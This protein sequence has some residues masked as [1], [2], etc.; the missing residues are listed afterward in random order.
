MRG[1]TSPRGAGTQGCR[2]S[3]WGS[4]WGGELLSPALGMLFPVLGNPS[5]ALQA[6]CGMQRSPRSRQT[7]SQLHRLWG[8]VFPFGENIAAKC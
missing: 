6:V 3:C 5:L 8:M 2:W 1:K 7:A 4:V